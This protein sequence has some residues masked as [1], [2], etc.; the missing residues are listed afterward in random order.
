MN[1]FGS[2]LS[3]EKSTTAQLDSSLAM[4]NIVLLLIFF[5][6]AS[7]SLLASRDVLVQLP[8]TAKLKLQSL[9][10]P[11]LEVAMDGSMVLDGVPVAIGGLADA[12]VDAPILYVLADR[13]DNAISLLEALEA[14]NLIAVELRLVTVHR[15]DD[16][17]GS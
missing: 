13:E 14:E 5:F 7:G 12:T 10:E 1:R 8:L 11:L 2:R 9:P 17:S 3:S 6:I 16:E 4:V 15:N